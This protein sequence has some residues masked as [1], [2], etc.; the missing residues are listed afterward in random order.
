MIPVKTS[1]KILF[2]IKASLIF[3][4]AYFNEKPDMD[5]CGFLIY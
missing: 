4:E 1:C 3:I 2:I 5:F